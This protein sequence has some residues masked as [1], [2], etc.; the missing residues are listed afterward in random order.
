ML[1]T[2]QHKP[3]YMPCLHL[4]SGSAKTVL[5]KE[6]YY[7]RLNLAT[8]KHFGTMLLAR[9]ERPLKPADPVGFVE[10]GLC[11]ILLKET[12]LVALG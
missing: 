1:L 3:I 12:R 5:I 9:V 8:W 4:R 2:L 11:A 6:L 7:P 10:R